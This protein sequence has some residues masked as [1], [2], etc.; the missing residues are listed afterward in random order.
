MLNLDVASAGFIFT[1]DLV[2][3]FVPVIIQALIDQQ[4]I[5]GIYI[6]DYGSVLI[7]RTIDISAP[8]NSVVSAG[9][10][11]EFFNLL[12][13]IFNSSLGSS[14]SIGNHF[15]IHIFF[16]SFSSGVSDSSNS[17]ACISDSSSF[18][19]C[20]G[21]CSTGIIFFYECVFFNSSFA[22]CSIS[23]ITGG[24][25]LAAAACK[26]GYCKRRVLLPSK[27]KEML[28]SFDC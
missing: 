4:L 27:E 23:S 8:L 28:V 3:D 1:Q 24:V 2:G 26:N 20:S 14:C 9:L 12:S 21:E 17:I 11:N 18:L 5:I 6:V 25:A 16:S 15:V 22:C 13:D 10:G 7:G 19:D